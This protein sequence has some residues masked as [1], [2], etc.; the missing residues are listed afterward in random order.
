M[1][2][3]ISFFKS[4]TIATSHLR[5][6]RG[7]K[8]NRI[9]G[10]KSIGKTR[11]ATVYYSGKS[12][13]DNYNNICELYQDG[14]INLSG[15]EHLFDHGL[16]ASKFQYQLREMV[17]ILAP[18]AKTIKC[19]ESTHSTVSDVFVFWLAITASIHDTLASLKD[20]LPNAVKESIRAAVNYR[21]KQMV[22]DAAGSMRP[23]AED[24]YITGFVLDP[25]KFSFQLNA[26]SYYLLLVR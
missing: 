11:F 21:F 16:A 15:V 25:R 18:I 17:M 13:V 3:T 9:G 4:S 12:L 20:G 24:V 14:A 10:L 1:R 7:Q 8:S 22:G 2:R 5:L 6:K 26:F 23:K 19:L